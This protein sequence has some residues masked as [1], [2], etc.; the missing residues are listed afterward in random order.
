[1]V[2]VEQNEKIR[3]SEVGLLEI[4]VFKDVIPDSRASS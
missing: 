3:G 2:N 4:R 1:M